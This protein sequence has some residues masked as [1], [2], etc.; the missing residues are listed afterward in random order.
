MLLNTL[1]AKMLKTF[2]ADVTARKTFK[3]SKEQSERGSKRVFKICI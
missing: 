3:N 2:I 1:K